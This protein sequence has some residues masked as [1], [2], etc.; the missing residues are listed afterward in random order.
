LVRDNDRAYGQVFTSRVRAMG[1][2]P[3][4]KFQLVKAFQRGGHA[5]GM[6]TLPKSADSEKAAKKI[7][8]KAA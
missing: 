2:F 3:E 8:V 6:I 7:T 1:I 5:V 4:Q